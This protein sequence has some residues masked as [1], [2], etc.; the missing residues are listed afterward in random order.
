MSD[1]GD[2]AGNPIIR[3][4]TAKKALWRTHRNPGRGPARRDRRRAQ[5][6]LGQAGGG[7][8]HLAANLGRRYP[9]SRHGWRLGRHLPRLRGFLSTLGANYA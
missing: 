1:R 3:E 9:D 4:D 8:R 5:H 2:V 7:V 6:L